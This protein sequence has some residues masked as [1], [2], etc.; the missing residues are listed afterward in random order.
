MRS[1]KPLRKA[2][3]YPK[4][5][6]RMVAGKPNR[7]S[8]S[9]EGVKE[10]YFEKLTQ[11]GSAS[12][13]F[14]P[15]PVSH[16]Q[17]EKLLAAYM[18]EGDRMAANI[19]KRWNEQSLDKYLLPHPLLGKVTVREMMFFTVFHTDHHDKIIHRDLKS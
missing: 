18:R 9:F 12:G 13:K 6:I 14:I 3:A 7:E 19:R 11:G 4:F 8:R 2:L 16:S 5:V 15:P 17:K 1:A 10:R